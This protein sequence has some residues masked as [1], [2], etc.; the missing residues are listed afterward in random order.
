MLN[1]DPWRARWT[2]KSCAMEFWQGS[3]E[4]ASA[5]TPP[6]L[7]LI[8]FIWE[9]L[10]KQNYTFYAFPNLSSCPNMCAHFLN[11]ISLSIGVFNFPKRSST[12]SVIWIQPLFL[13][14]ITLTS[15][16][17]SRNHSGL[18]TKLK[19]GRQFIY[20]SK[21]NLRQ[22]SLL[23][24]PQLLSPRNYWLSLFFFYLSLSL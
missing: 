22:S 9:S 12:F 21:F 19:C 6:L 23:L 13:L 11:R 5:R 2:W 3:L 10:F 4:V 20:K 1:L 15:S 8:T 7:A 18:W 17:L 16:T 14:I 24:L